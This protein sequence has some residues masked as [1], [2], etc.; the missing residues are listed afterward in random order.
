MQAR[1]CRRVRG[2]RGA[3]H[4]RAGGRGAHGC[5]AGAATARGH[6]ARRGP[7][8]SRL[9]RRRPGR[10]R[11]AARPPPA[12]RRRRGRHAA[13]RRPG[14]P[15]GAPRRRRR[16]DRHRARPRGRARH[17]PVVRETVPAQGHHRRTRRQPLPLRRRRDR[18]VRPRRI[19]E[20]PRRWRG[21]DLLRRRQRGRRRPGH[22][23][24]PLRRGRPGPRRRGT[25][26]RSRRLP[27]S[28]PAHRAERHDQHDRRRRHHRAVGHADPRPVRAHV[29]GRHRA[30]PGRRLLGRQP[31][32]ALHRQ[33]PAAARRRPRHGHRGPARPTALLHASARRR[34]GRHPV[35]RVRRL[36]PD[37]R[38]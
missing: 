23:G 27:G 16:G 18:A 21:R 37:R 9:L 17:R 19:L 4:R 6:A 13:D 38:R 28:R 2:V 32:A 34:T 3:G 14:Q 10:D 24:V 8:G 25:G 1:G 36:R 5:R 7:R 15:P 12:D 11:G 33:R 35:R 29:P 31:A 26:L 22:R 20:D 30:R